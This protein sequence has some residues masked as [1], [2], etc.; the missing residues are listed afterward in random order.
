MP[1]LAPH[2]LHTL[3]TCPIFIKGKVA[4]AAYLHLVLYVLHLS[5]PLFICNFLAA[6]KFMFM[7]QYLTLVFKGSEHS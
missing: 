2:P 4:H 6:V 1:P 3:C 7:I 5:S